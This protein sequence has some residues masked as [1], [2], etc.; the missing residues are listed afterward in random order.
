[1]KEESKKRIWCENAQVKLVSIV[2]SSRCI[3]EMI[4]SFNQLL[5]P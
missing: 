3:P 2:F 1:M 4:H 5:N